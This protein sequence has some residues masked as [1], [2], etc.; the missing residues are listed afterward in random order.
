M[1]QSKR[2]ILRANDL[3]KNYGSHNVLSI[4]KLEIHPGTIYGI[5]GTIGSSKT[6]LLNI[7]AGI[8]KQTSGTVLYENNSYETNWL[9]KVVANKDVFYTKKTKLD[10]PNTIVSN[11]VTNLVGKKKKIIQNRY[12]IDG[13]FNN[14][15]NRNIRDLSSGEL[16]W[17]GLILACESDPRVLLIDDYGVYFNDKMEKDFRGKL[18]T[19]NRTLGTTIILSSPTDKNLKYFASV[20]IYLDHGHIWKIRPGMSR[21]TNKKKYQP[22]HNKINK[23]Y[24]K[25]QKNSKP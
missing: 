21:N 13:G 22:N 17:L 7:L 19:M 11:Y 5:V 4:K 2:V 18:A 6:T 8:E 20:L 24:K 14:L 25:N 12:F 1:A 10:N 9:G 15:W 23:R 3:E 16:N